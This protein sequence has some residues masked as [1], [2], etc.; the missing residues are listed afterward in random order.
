MR[1]HAR[2]DRL[3]RLADLDQ[4]NADCVEDQAIAECPAPQM[5]LD[6]GHGAHDVVEPL[7]S[8]LVMGRSHLALLVPRPGAIPLSCGGSRRGFR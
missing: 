3:D 7:E 8:R 5:I 4:T 6:R 2:V 1:E